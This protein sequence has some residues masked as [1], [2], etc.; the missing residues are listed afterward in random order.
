MSILTEGR[1]PFSDDIGHQNILACGI[2]GHGKSFLAATMPGRIAYLCVES[3]AVDNIKQAMIM[4]GRRPEEIRVF[5]IKKHLDPSDPAGRR[6]LKGAGGKPLTAMQYLRDLLS[7]LETDPS[8]FDSVVLDSLTALQEAEKF[9][10]QA[11]KDKM[12]QRDWGEIIDNVTEVCVKLRDLRLHTMAIA[13]T[14]VVQDD[15][16]RMFQ[17]LSVFGKKLPTD[18]PRYFNLAVTMMK[19][20]DPSGVEVHKAVTSAGEKYIT[21]GHLALEQ[22]EEPDVRKWFEKMNTFWGEHGQSDIP[23]EGVVTRE[24]PKMSAAEAATQERLNHPE[25]KRLFDL[26]GAP[27]AKRLVT[28]KKYRSLDKLLEVLKGRVAD[29]VD[30]KKADLDATKEPRSEDPTPAAK[31]PR[32]EDPAPAAKK[33]RSGDPDPADEAEATRKGAKA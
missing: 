7:A 18:L 19:K 4:H 32:S 16:S 29:R 10:I 26:L 1:N 33:P 21:K 8:G 9:W 12:S 27:D 17:R 20:T 25:V 14:T 3:Q 11:D 22:V 15:E 5:E 30:E 28:V 2:A 31:E 24:A 23:Q 6:L 13:T